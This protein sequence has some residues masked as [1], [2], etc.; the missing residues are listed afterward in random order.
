MKNLFVGNLPFRLSE[1]ELAQ[2][3]RAL[4]ES[5]GVVDRVSVIT[6]RETGKPRGFAF[7]E[8]ED[9]E[10]A[11][12]AIAGLNGTDFEGRPLNVSEAK[13][14]MDRGPGGPGGGRAGRGGGDRFR[15]PRW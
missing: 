8:M 5:F 14:R 1:A 10:A 9:E 4:F 3:L 7:V 13:P 15:E 2:G 11:E 6:D 12:R